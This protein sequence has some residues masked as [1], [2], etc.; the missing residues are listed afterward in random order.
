[1]IAIAL[2]AL[3]GGILTRADIGHGKLAECE[4]IEYTGQTP[5]TGDTTRDWAAAMDAANV[6]EAGFILHWMR[7]E[8]KV[9]PRSA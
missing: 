5:D 8:T 3:N 6:P 4:R 2:V 9:Q 1:M 7:G